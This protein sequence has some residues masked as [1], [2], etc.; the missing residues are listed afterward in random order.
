MNDDRIH[1]LLGSFDVPAVSEDQIEKC[2]AASKRAYRPKK[3]T[4][5]SSVF[6]LLKTQISYMTKEYHAMLSLL[7]VLASIVLCIELPS[8]FP[9]F[10]GR[11]NILSAVCIGSAPVFIAPV[12]TSVMLSAKSG[13]TELEASC[14]YNLQ[15]LVFARMLIT[16]IIAFISMAVIWLVSGIRTEDYSINRLLFSVISF[17]ITAALILGFGKRSI[18]SGITAASVWAAVAIAFLM[19]SR[20]MEFIYT[21]NLSA[22]LIAF[23][24]T[25]AAALS[26]A[27]N[28]MKNISFESEE[29]KWNFALTD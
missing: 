21:V 10:G 11:L 28:Y 18:V 27:Y 3:N 17:N 22:V 23:A 9:I 26:M 24:A 6:T 13:M 14:K 1:E 2:I 12:V 29:R 19:S 16:G 8:I 5:K 7:A 25:L 20:T 15:K 4:K